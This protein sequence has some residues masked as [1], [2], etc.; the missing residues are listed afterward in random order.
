[1]PSGRPIA[2]YGPA[3]LVPAAWVLTILAHVTTVVTDQVL[4][5]ALTVMSIVLVVFLLGARDELSE[6]ALR[7][8]KRVLAA[9]F[10]ITVIGIVDLLAT[11]GTNEVLAVTL[12]G[13]MVIPA[14]GLAQ[15]ATLVER[16]PGRYRLFA[17]VTMAGGVVY[18]VAP[19]VPGARNVLL[20]AGLVV[21]GTGQT[22]GVVNAAYHNAQQSV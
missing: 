7:P 22:G 21:V 9:G 13:W 12:Y 6:G 10:I 16:T 17:G 2:D 19:L 3:L 11:P 4:L 8:W 20:V 15:T 18:F 1:M 5:I 14:L